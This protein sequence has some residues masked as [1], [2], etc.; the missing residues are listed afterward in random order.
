ML[1]GGSCVLH[2]QLSCLSIGQTWRPLLGSACKQQLLH[3]VP[4]TQTAVQQQ[5]LM[6]ECTAYVL[7]VCRQAA[8]VRTKMLSMVVQA[9]KVQLSA[10]S[11]EQDD[12]EAETEVQV[13]LLESG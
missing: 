9:K 8:R 4:E 12:A 6:E 10:A 13:P 1:Q 11:D 3:T 5:S 2:L 7:V